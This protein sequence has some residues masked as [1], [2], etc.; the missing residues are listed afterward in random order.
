MSNGLY[1]DE[2]FFKCEKDCAVFVALDRL[3][4][5]RAPVVPIGIKSLFSANPESCVSGSK[6]SKNLQKQKSIEQ[7]QKQQLYFKAGDRVIA[8]D[9]D[10]RIVHGTVK[11][12]GGASGSENLV[13]IETVS[14]LYYAY[15]ILYYTFNTLHGRLK[16]N[17]CATIVM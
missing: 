13:G 12:T 1:K 7:Q 4:E 2:E 10:E 3:S 6:N 16:A 9:N 8:F 5:N 11:W 14:N 15:H 17:F